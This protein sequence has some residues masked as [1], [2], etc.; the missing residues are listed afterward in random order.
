MA[1]LWAKQMTLKTEVSV[2]GYKIIHFCPPRPLARAVRTSGGC[3]KKY[4]I[5]WEATTAKRNYYRT[6]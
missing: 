2:K 5:I 6:N 3:R 1:M 4:L